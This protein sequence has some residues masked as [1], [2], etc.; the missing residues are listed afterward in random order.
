MTSAERMRLYRARKRA[1]PP[2]TEA[3][4][5]LAVPMRRFASLLHCSERHCYHLAAFQR[6]SAIK[7]SDD[8]LNGKHGRVGA[9]FLAEVCEHGDAAAQK[10]IRD[11]IEEAGAA[12]GRALWQQFLREADAQALMRKHRRRASYR[13]RKRYEDAGWW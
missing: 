9:E 13:A 5:K 2:L 3:E 8:I 1:P 12:A 7:W 4:S 11:K 6:H 10:A